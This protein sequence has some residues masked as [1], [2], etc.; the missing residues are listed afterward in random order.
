M[1]IP[2]SMGDMIITSQFR[3]VTNGQPGFGFEV[4]RT[5]AC[6]RASW[7]PKPRPHSTMSF[8]STIRDQ[9]AFYRNLELFIRNYLPDFSSEQIVFA[10]IQP[11]NFHFF[12]FLF[13]NFCS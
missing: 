4:F 6:R 5:A 10:K 13:F 9:I 11:R 8:R 7:R 1:F 12:F 2:D 3:D